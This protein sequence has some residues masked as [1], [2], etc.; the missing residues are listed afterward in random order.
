[1]DVESAYNLV[2]KAIDTGRLAHGYL[3]VGDIKKEC[4]RLVD[5]VLRRLFPDALAQIAAKSHPDVAWLEPEGKSRTIHILSMRE[6]IIAP[7]S[8]SSFS[9]GWK[10]GVIIGADRM[11]VAAA[12]AFL[13][14]LEEPTPQTIFLMLTD[15]PDAVLPTIVSRSQRIDLPLGEGILDKNR[16][17][18]IKAIFSAARGNIGSFERSKIA[19]ALSELFADIK[20]DAEPEDTPIVR[21]K[22]FKSIMK[23]VREWMTSHALEEYKAFRNIDAVEE[24]YRQS[25]RAINDETVLCFLMDRLILPA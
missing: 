23:L 2:S 1:M 7:M 14:T 25:E 10:A 22:F 12:N 3:V 8:A 16:N 4:S 20:A 6:K 11:E 21:K 18:N 19:K 15:N 5:L 24:A 17:D 13:K 9:G